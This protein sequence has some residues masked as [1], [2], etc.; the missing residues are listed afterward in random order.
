MKLPF[1]TR[2]RF[3]NERG[4]TIM[5]VPVDTATRKRLSKAISVGE[6][7][8]FHDKEIGWV[9]RKEFDDYQAYLD[10]RKKP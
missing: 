5:Y 9:E 7:Y 3:E 8:A 2:R 1:I 10:W 6:Q 4:R